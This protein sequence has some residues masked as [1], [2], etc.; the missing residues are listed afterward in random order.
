VEQET[1]TSA[2]ARSPLR[3]VVHEQ[4]GRLVVTSLLFSTHQLGE[5]AVPVV[6]GLIIDRAVAT[7]DEAALARWVGVLLLVF[8]VFSNAY[9]IGARISERGRLQSQHRMVLAVTDRV[10][11]PAGGADAA[12]RPGAL[13]STAAVDAETTSRIVEVVGGGVASVVAMV[14][15]AIAL[16]TISVPLG[17]M[18]L[19]G[20]P[21][22]VALLQVLVRPIEARVSEQREEAT[23]AAGI[24][25]DLVSGLRVLKGLGVEARA[26]RR[27]HA[28]SRRSL[29]AG[30]RAAD[31]E[32]M[33][34]GAAVLTTGV[35][36]A[37][38]V[39]VGGGLAVDDDITIGSLIAAVGL[40]LFLVGPLLRIGFFGALL[41]HARAGSRRVQDV[42]EVEPTV[43][44]G[45]EEPEQ[46]VRGELA[47]DR[48]AGEHLREVTLTV[49]AGRLVGL[50]VADPAEAAELLAVLGRTTDPPAGEVRLDGRPMAALDLEA[51]RR[52]VLVSHH[53]A[54]LFSGTIRDNVDPGDGRD[55]R[56]A[57]EAADADEV[58]R[59]QP[60][61]LD[62]LVTERGRSLSGGQKQRV[63]LARALALDPP[64]LV[65][66][67]PTTAVDAAT[68]A[69]VAGS[70]RRLREGRTT[71]VLTTSPA[72][73]AVADHVAFV[74]EG[75]VVAE[76]THAQLV[77]DERYAEVVLR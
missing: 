24:A 19:V 4:R 63:A 75:R 22:V 16:L 49:P 5:M 60:D 62:T 46:P 15:C 29:A 66:H 41:G 1:S 31:V 39:F 74:H 8:L 51:A 25:A 18:V 12:M 56:P 26:A 47:F 73:L 32:A 33:H 57:L 65:L 70:L 58:A 64:V 2:P 14:T 71:V 36:I 68:E 48:L 44:A 45:T 55:L 54:E 23:A 40:S 17:L 34:E 37:A 50:A 13:V 76:G 20:L 67:D 30:V 59:T 10:L 38:V 3:Q 43:V 6:V 27:Y 21:V 11:H 69:Q 53:D 72:L 7:G 9:R 42:L 28:V 52:A 77:D 61:G 35:V